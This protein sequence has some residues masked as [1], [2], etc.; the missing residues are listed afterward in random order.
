MKKISLLKK[1]ALTSTLLLVSSLPIQAEVTDMSDNSF[2]VK[3]SFISHKDTSTALHQFGHVGLWW[4]SEFTQSGKG[5]N[6]FFNGKGLYENMPNGEVITHLTKVEKGDN[7]WVWHG[8]LG[9][10]K[11]EKVN[12]KMKVSIKEHHHC[13]RIS[14]EYTVKGETLTEHQAW[15]KYIDNMLAVQMESLK[16]SLNKR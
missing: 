5:Q 3:H 14:M 12:G 8:S 9:K 15:P 13:T 10:L 11:N 16:D 7:E 2:T 1:V 6:M 4:T